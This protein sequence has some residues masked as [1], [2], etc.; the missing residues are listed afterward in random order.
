MLLHIEHKTVYS[1][2]EPIFYNIQQLRL[3]PQQGF[4]QHV[5]RWEI[6]VSGHLYE[7]VDSYGNT[8]HT[9]VME[10]EH[11]EVTIVARG[12]VETGLDF[13]ANEDLLPIIIYLR[14]TPLT[15]A[16][17]AIRS[18]VRQFREQHTNLH[19]DNIL[20]LIQA[21]LAQVPRQ[22][23]TTGV[24][25]SAAQAFSLGAGVCQDQTHIF[26]ACCRLLGVP[27]RYVSGYLFTADSSLMES[28]AW[29]DVWLEQ[30]GWQSYD[31]ANASRTNGL[32][33][34]LA[35]GLDYRDAS[36]VNGMRLGGGEENMTVHVEVRQMPG[37]SAHI[38]GD[39]AI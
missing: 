23:G 39:A 33:V 38:D 16:S 17:E 32:H 6:K 35:T 28:H 36:P 2:S 11:A 29:A 27:A 15:Q 37:V 5:S 7:Y 25:T 31:V 20:A 19:A 24:G 14:E 8:T 10:G 1:Y 30:S 34:R 12:V 21:I 9:L 22:K 13:T 4:G 3:T 18:F 26:I